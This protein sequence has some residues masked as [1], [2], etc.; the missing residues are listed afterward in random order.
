MYIIKLKIN[1]TIYIYE[2]SSYR[3][4]RTGKIKT[5]R[6]ICGKIDENGNFI[7]SKGRTLNNLPAKII[8]IT[9]II[10]KFRIVETKN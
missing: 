6:K 8:E 4:K 5:K 2:Q 7:P 9:K 3:D 10:K 1:D